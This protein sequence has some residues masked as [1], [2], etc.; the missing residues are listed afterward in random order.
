MKTRAITAA[1]VVGAVALGL[2]LGVP[3][4]AS[5]EYAFTRIDVP[6]ATVTYANGNTTH[7]IV[8]EFD[9]EDGNTHGF[10]LSKGVFARFDA[11][12]A[13][14]YTSINGINGDGQRSG[15]YYDGNRY[16]GYSWSKG[17][18][19]TLDP[20]GSTFSAALFLNVR[21]QVVG[22]SRDAAGTRH[23]FVWSKGFFTQIDAPE[24]AEPDGTRAVGIN[25]RG[26][27]VGAYRGE[28][29]QLHG[30]L[31]SG[32]AFTTLDAPGAE[33]GVTY[34]EGINNSGTIVGFYADADGTSHGFVLSRGVYTTVD[35][36]GALWTEVYSINAKGQILGTYEDADGVHGFLGAPVQFPTAPVVEDQ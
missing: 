18:F 2:L 35:V 12:G 17:V 21:G 29:G 30:F 31:L 34:A 10:V 22:Y 20:P 3:G 13:D 33:G 15:I 7:R 6:E 28:D 32:G 16:F 19:T 23:G 27:I 4:L 36:P 9:D 5:A 1:T 24:A 8:G 25:D 14:G 26:E 11:P